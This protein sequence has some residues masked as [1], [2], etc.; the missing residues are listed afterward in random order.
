MERCRMRCSECAGIESD[1]NCGGGLLPET[2]SIAGSGPTENCLKY[3]SSA[4][5]EAN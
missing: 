4:S 2:N 5:S 1:S 3:G